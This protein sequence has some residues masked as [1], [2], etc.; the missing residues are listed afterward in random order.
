MNHRLLTATVWKVF[1]CYNLL[2]N[3][4]IKQKIVGFVAVDENHFQF[5]TK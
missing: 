4:S 3:K 5:L 1:L 2:L